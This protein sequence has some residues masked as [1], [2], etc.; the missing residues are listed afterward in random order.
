MARQ[1]RFVISD[2][3]T[4]YHLMS[5]VAGPRSWY[6]FQD[7]PEAAQQFVRILIH[8]LSVYCGDLL[9]FVLMGNHFHLLVRFLAYR[10][11]SQRELQ[12]RAARLYPRPA[13]R[14]QTPRQWRQFNRRLFSV[15]S[16]MH[17][18]KQQMAQWYNRRF[19]R[20]GPLFSDRFQS[21]L[22]G[23]HQAV[24]NCLLYIALNPVRAGLVQRPE[25]WFWSGSRLRATGT[26]PPLLPLSTIL[27]AASDPCQQY[28]MR[29]YWRG[30]IQTPPT[31]P[32]LDPAI[33]ASEIRRGFHSGAYLEVQPELTRGLGLASFPQVSTWIQ[34]LR[35]RGIYRRRRHPIAQ[36]NGPLFTIRESRAPHRPPPQ[37]G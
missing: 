33:V 6:P 2:R 8:Y 36:P 22:L 27:P 16:F 24:L 4:W 19:E 21:V 34:W 26:A 10:R 1:P 25:Q 17:D 13:D 9:D 5:R 32:V 28:L 23:D 3:D 18:V 11:L 7:D 37:P 31:G 30:G 12:R 35:Q 20:R 29:L 15:S 14:P